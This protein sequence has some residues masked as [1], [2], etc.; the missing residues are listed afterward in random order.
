MGVVHESALQC[1]VLIHPLAKFPSQTPY[2]RGKVP[3][4]LSFSFITSEEGH[5]FLFLFGSKRQEVLRH[6]VD[7]LVL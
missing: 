5:L 6:V 3:P 4:C 7:L 1:E 2:E